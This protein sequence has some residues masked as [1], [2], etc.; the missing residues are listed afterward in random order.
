MTIEEL[1]KKTSIPRAPL[2]LTRENTVLLLIDM[3]GLAGSE[4]I[5][6]KAVEYGV[7]PEEARR[8]CQPYA[9]QV[10]ACNRQAGRLLEAFRARN[11]TPI[12]VRIQA[13]SGDGRD[14]GPSHRR[15]GFIYP[16]GDRWAAFMEE[17][18]PN[19]EEIVLSKTCSGCVTGTSLDRI[20][21]NL[22]TKYVITVGYYTDQ[23]VET[24]I[25]DLHDQGYDV[26]LALDATGTPTQARYEAT[27][28]SCVGVYCR[29]LYTDD[30]LQALEGIP[31]V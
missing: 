31:P 13:Y 11:M 6:E 4:Y 3:Q 1:L 22:N 19:P 21:R 5:V 9:H 2:A 17:V 20:L 7:D 26:T 30:V 28:E 24:T 8:A 29:G 10:E 27:I 12:H 14:V 25:R 18:A 16:P 15:V 23:C